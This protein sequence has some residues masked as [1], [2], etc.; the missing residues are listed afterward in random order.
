MLIHRGGGDGDV[1]AS[2]IEAGHV[3]A[4]KDEEAGG[5]WVVV[6][7]GIIVFADGKAIE[8]I[9]KEGKGFWA[10]WVV[11]ELGVARVGGVLVGAVV[12]GGVGERG[13]LEMAELVGVEGGAGADVGGLVGWTWGVVVEVVIWIRLEEGHWDVDR[14]RRGGGGS[15]ARGGEE[16]GRVRTWSANWG[17]LAFNL[18]HTRSDRRLPS[19]PSLRSLSP[20]PS[21]RPR[22]GPL[23]AAAAPSVPAVLALALA[24]GP[25]GRAGY[26]RRTGISAS[27]HLITALAGQPS[28]SGNQSRPR[29]ICA[30]RFLV[31]GHQA[32]PRS[33]WHA[34][35]LLR[36]NCLPCL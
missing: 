33:T 31:R 1:G 22:L 9:A 27:C 21:L 5:G 2:G 26:F 19:T 4:V 6:F 32:R 36:R 11:A 3:L 18:R 17:A 23:A 28:S 14:C 8:T 24:A 30:S 20:P 7:G 25:R 13:G 12:G 29:P 16:E 35:S 15:E 34:V 10:V